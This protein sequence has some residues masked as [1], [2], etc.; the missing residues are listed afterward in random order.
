[1]AWRVYFRRGDRY[2]AATEWSVSSKVFQQKDVIAMTDNDLVIRFDYNNCLASAVGEVDGLT[3]A[4]IDAMAAQVPELAKRMADQR[5]GGA[6]PYRD[7]PYQRDQLDAIL[8]S[9]AEKKGRFDNVV[10]LGIGGSSLGTIAVNTACNHPFFNLLPADE[11]GVPR[12]FVMDNVDPAWF[13]GVLHIVDAARTL[14]VVISKSGSTA[15]TM[16]Q[17]LICRDLLKKTLGADYAKNMVAIT[18]TTAGFLRP[19]AEGEGYETF[20]V[21][22]GVGGRWSVLSPVGLFPL[23]MVGVDI[24]QL[25]AGAAAMDARCKTDDLRANPAF[26]SAVVQMLF[27]ERG[28]PMSVMMPYSQALRD[29]ADWYRQL[30]A[31]SLGKIRAAGSGVEFVGPTPVKALGVTD[32]HSQVQLYREGPNDKIFT[33]IAVDDFG[34]DLS[35]PSAFPDS[36]GV[37]YLGDHT[38][39]E[40]MDAERRATTYAL[41]ISR[42]PN[43]TIRLPKVNAHT[44]GQ[45]LTLL[46]VQTSLAGELLGIN[47]YDQPGVEAGKVATYALM[48]RPSYEDN[49]EEIEKRQADD[50]FII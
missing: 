20:A 41:T 38:M 5:A 21:P 9:V 13:G 49:R 42:R 50:A 8:R 2:H 36:E 45:L 24:E 14:F 17:F 25:L 47:A 15:E 48:G 4:E 46:E 12:L 34:T 43:V 16:T 26:M 32:Q 31:E 1:M 29:V 40:L 18:D 10:V 33:L 39:A 19:I 22:D 27:Y 35:I 11:R 6:L 30:W 23:A 37:A 28:K 3:D 7:L 44:V